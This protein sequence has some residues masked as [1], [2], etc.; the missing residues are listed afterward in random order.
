MGD[1]RKLKV[2]EKAENLAA[3]VLLTTAASRKRSRG[4]LRSQ[5]DRAA[6]SISANIAE[7]KSGRSDDD[8]VRFLQ[9]A[10]GSCNELESHLSL[11]Q[12]V[13]FIRPDDFQRLNTQLEEVRKMLSG[14][15]RYLRGRLITD[16]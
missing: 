3:D 1:F 9:I 7:A 2:W 14:L 11:G 16:A 10:V 12:R 6:T 13:G 5:A 4:N 15:I 8:Q